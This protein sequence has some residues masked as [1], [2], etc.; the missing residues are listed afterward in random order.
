MIVLG[1][2]VLV[3]WFFL[4]AARAGFWRSAIR[5][6]DGP[7]PSDWPP[8]TAVIPARDEAEGIGE[9][10]A[11]LVQQD[12][13]GPFSIILVDDQSSDGTAEIAQRAAIVAGFAESLTIL[14]GKALPSGWPGKPWA[15][16]QGTEHAQEG[17]PIYLLLTDGDIVLSTDM[18]SRLVAKAH[19]N[20]PALYSV[21]AKLRC[22]SLAERALVPAFMFFFQML[23]PFAWVNR[24]ESRTAAAAGGCML[25]RL[26]TLRAAGGIDSIRDALMDD[27][28]LANKLKR[29][30]PIRLALTDRVHSTRAYP[31][32]RD[33]RRV[34][35]R[36][37][38][39]QL[40][41]SPLPLL[42]ATSMTIAYLSP[43]I[44]TLFGRGTA[45]V[46]GIL[47]CTII[48]IAFQPTLRFY[49]LWPLCGTLLPAI[50]LVDTAFTLDSAY[51]HAHGA[52]GLWK[53]RVQAGVG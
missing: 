5:D 3:V 20:G 12:Y 39:A 10:I 14:A 34:I 38:Y 47:V 35:I 8:V 25:V 4:I 36:S 7:A 1:C 18:L 37:A 15:L 42:L 44:L 17:S 2:A 9:C 48:A 49:R 13:Q 11:C 53:G 40:C 28:A 33:F 21:M 29:L 6:E 46:L 31:R 45:Q 24:P 50:A 22:A 27:C 16:K 26:D 23:Y 32:L 30:E 51:Q 43:V 52:G 19:A 41:Y